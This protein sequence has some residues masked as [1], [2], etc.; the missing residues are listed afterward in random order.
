MFLSSSLS[1]SSISKQQVLVIVIAATNRISIL[2]PA[3]LRP[4]RFDRH[5]MVPPPDRAGRAAILAIH[6]RNVNLNDNLCLD[7]FAKDHMTKGFTGADLK[8]VVNEAALL[9]VRSGS[10]TVRENH[11]KEAVRRIQGM[12]FI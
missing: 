5:V 7:D 12:K 2:D 6:A 10:L 11:M 4:G 8:N 9:A 1:P 3:I